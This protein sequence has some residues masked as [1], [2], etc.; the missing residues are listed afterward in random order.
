MSKSNIG[1]LEAAA[2]VASIIKGVLAMENGLIPPN[3]HYSKPNPKI[4]LEKWKMAVPNKLTPWPTCQTKRMSVSSFGMRGTNAHFVL[5]EGSRSSN[6]NG[7]TYA[8]IP[9][10]RLFVF[11]SRGRAGFQRHRNALVEHLDKLGPAA[12]SSEYLTN[13][14]HTLAAA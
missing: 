3:I 13:L 9:K 4:P 14:A 12:S 10:K 2:G 1:H 8:L 6:T 7:E 5:E 11:G